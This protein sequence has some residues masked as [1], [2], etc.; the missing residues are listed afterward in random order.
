MAR[1][2]HLRHDIVLGGPDAPPLAVSAED[3]N[4]LF[5]QLSKDRDT[6]NEYA[7]LRTKNCFP[8]QRVGSSL[9]LCRYDPADLSPLRQLDFVV[10]VDIYHPFLK[11]HNEPG[12]KVGKDPTPLDDSL[13]SDGF[14]V[15]SDPKRRVDVII[16][17]HSDSRGA[18]PT[19]DL[20]LKLIDDGI[21]DQSELELYPG[22][23]VDPLDFTKE[24][25]S[26]YIGT[27]VSVDQL[28]TIAAHDVVYQICRIGPVEWH[29]EI[30]RNLCLDSVNDIYNARIPNA[31]P[32][33]GKG[34]VIHFHDSGFDTGSILDT[35]PAFHPARIAALYN[36]TGQPG[37][38]DDKDNHGT[39]VIG[40][41]VGDGFSQA[42]ADFAENNMNGKFQ[43]GR[44]RGIAP[45]A[46]FVCT[47]K[48]GVGGRM[49][50]K[51]AGAADSPYIIHGARISNH[52]YGYPGIREY[53]PASEQID[54]YL[55]YHDDLLAVFSAGNRGRYNTTGTLTSPAN[56]KNALSVGNSFSTRPLNTPS[57]VAVGD[58]LTIFHTSSCGPTEEGQVKPDMVA[59]GV[60]ILT[61]RS[62]A[63]PPTARPPPLHNDG[64]YNCMT[65]TSFSAPFVS[66][67]A[68]LVREAL[69]ERR[70]V[71]PS[72]A[73]VKALLLNGCV[74]AEPYP[75]D[76]QQQRDLPNVTTG[77]GRV[78][79][80]GSMRSIV[81]QQL[82]ADLNN[83]VDRPKTFR[84]GERWT[85]TIAIPRA[86]TI[87][88]GGPR[89]PH[90]FKATLVWT[91]KPGKNL[92]FGLGLSVIATD[93][94]GARGRY[95][96][97][98]SGTWQTED[99]QYFDTNNNVQ[100]V[101]WRDM[102]EGELTMEV[103]CIKLAIDHDI[104]NKWAL[105]WSFE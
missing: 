8:L 46:R 82:P 37:V 9:Y 90:T 58:P 100:Q 87:Y 56:T 53:I 34:Q 25:T 43:S 11:I 15:G 41:A 24:D 44:V 96:G 66:G 22:Y 88:P 3:T 74:K 94:N 80:G 85:Q 69:A 73:L 104:F 28:T 47:K 64:L 6:P 4:Y 35:H 42:V 52:S 59:P 31:T 36:L 75:S 51:Y 27:R 17:L 63:A 5:V 16:A 40:V 93:C 98:A 68:A 2:T 102:R 92:Q 71:N 49:F 14:A 20:V 67:C 86:A 38:P 29:D 21:M 72:A 84:L 13:P 39:G 48:P 12:L 83:F 78:N 33:T 50:S 7:L 91:D 101:I 32:Y 55:F 79:I 99:D 57:G 89:I 97:N 61:P 95:Y 19:R 65:G 1:F 30:Q 26:G 77:F 54:D 105:V 23:E 18:A 103:K 45:G 81:P 62:R 76:A 10:L 60:Q 70:C